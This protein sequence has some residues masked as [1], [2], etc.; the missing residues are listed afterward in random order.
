MATPKHFKLNLQAY[1]VIWFQLVKG[2]RQQVLSTIG[3]FMVPSSSTGRATES[4][5]TL[6]T[7]KIPSPSHPWAPTNHWKSA[8]VAKESWFPKIASLKV[9]CGGPEP[10][11][12]TLSDAIFGSQSWNFF[13]QQ[14]W[15]A[16]S[17]PSSGAR[18]NH[19]H[20]LLSQSHFLHI[21]WSIH[22]SQ[23]LTA[24]H[25]QEFVHFHNRSIHTSHIE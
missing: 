11:R 6:L 17:G 3:V 4:C 5:P 8:E 13:C 2:S 23:K 21:W 20:P 24:A 22:T 12:N 25:L 1:I 10:P 7:K 9:Y 16:F 19:E 15:A 18:W 14:C